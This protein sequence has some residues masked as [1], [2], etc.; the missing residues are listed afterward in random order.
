MVAAVARDKDKKILPWCTLYSTD[1]SG[2]LIKMSFLVISLKNVSHIWFFCYCYVSSLYDSLIQQRKRWQFNVPIALVAGS[3]G[4]ACG[5]TRRGCQPAGPL[6]VAIVLGRS[7]VLE[8]ARV[9]LC[10]RTRKRPAW[11]RMQD[12]PRFAARCSQRITDCTNDVSRG[13]C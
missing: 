6:T 5:F 9:P 2:H 13:D 12:E 10:A 1:V 8:E 7:H 11:M 4:K 3:P